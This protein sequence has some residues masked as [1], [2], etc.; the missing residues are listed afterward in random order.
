MEHYLQL[1]RFCIKCLFT[2]LI[3]FTRYWQRDQFGQRFVQVVIE[4]LVLI[5]L[6]GML[7]PH[8]YQ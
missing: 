2:P 5:H 7:A 4:I 3:D 8:L 1:L 6:L